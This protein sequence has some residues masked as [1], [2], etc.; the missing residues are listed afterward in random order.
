MA[1]LLGHHRLVLRE[2]P[3]LHVREGACPGGRGQGARAFRGRPRPGE[4]WSER[5][6]V[7]GIDAHLMLAVGPRMGGDAGP[8]MVNLDRPL[9]TP[10]DLDGPSRLVSSVTRQ[11]GATFRHST[12]AR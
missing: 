4:A 9:M 1:H 2:W 7:D 12:V 3:D 11:A 10:V 5:L 6:G 8:L